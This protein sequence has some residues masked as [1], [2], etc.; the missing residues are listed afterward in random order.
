MVTVNGIGLNCPLPAI[1][2]KQALKEMT[3]PGVVEVLVDNEIAVQNVTKM[4][5]SY[6][7]K[8]AS[9]QLGENEYKV[10]I[11]VDEIKVIEEEEEVV[12]KSA[13]NTVVVISSNCMGAG[14]DELGGALIKSFLYAVTQLDKL[15]S[16]VLF[17]NSGVKLVAEG[18]EVLD[19]LKFLQE[20]GVE[21]MA[22]GI[23]LDFFKLKE[24]V[25]VGTIGNMYSIVEI[26]NKAGRII[27][28]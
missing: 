8:V 27:R 12:V 2:T 7:G 25:A 6:G 3:E 24:K 18:S 28:P 1:K 20:Q 14:D 13:D 17:Y 10:T 19:D 5:E 11:T 21:L 22:C 23:C 16:H 15:P 9:E 26:Q 4:G